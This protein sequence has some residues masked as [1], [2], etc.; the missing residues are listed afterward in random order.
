MRITR[1]YYQ[2]LCKELEMRKMIRNSAVKAEADAWRS[3]LH[4]VDDE[5]RRY[6]KDV[7]DQ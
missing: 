3:M 6:R 2:E 5:S 4:D 7:K 1:E